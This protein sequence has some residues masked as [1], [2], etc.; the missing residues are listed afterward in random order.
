MTA[1]L[2]FGVVCWSIAIVSSLIAG[3]FKILI[4][5][6]FKMDQAWFDYEPSLKY[7][8]FKLR[9]EKDFAIKA[10]H[11]L[12]CLITNTFSIIGFILIAIHFF[13]NW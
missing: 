6:D 13:K 3:V 5:R 2:A 1:F 4:F 11:S 9:K 12:F 8:N 10:I 7:M